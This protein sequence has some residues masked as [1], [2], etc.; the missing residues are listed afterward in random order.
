[1]YRPYSALLSIE[2]DAERYKSPA[3]MSVRKRRFELTSQDGVGD[4]EYDGI[5]CDTQ[6]DTHKLIL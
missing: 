3:D 6:S 4:D 2:P 5:Q 1:M